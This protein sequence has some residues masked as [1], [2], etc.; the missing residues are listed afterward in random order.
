MVCGRKVVFERRGRVVLIAPSSCIRLVTLA[1]TARGVVER[2]KL[3]G[4]RLLIR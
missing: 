2:M 4:R 1:I 3:I